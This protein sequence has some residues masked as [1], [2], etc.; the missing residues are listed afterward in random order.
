MAAHPLSVLLRRGGRNVS[1]FEIGG[2][3]HYR[4]EVR[5]LRAFCAKWWPSCRL[6]LP[7]GGCPRPSSRK[8][9]GLRPTPSA[10]CD[11]WRSPAA[12]LPSSNAF[13]GIDIIHFAQ[14]SGPAEILINSGGGL[15]SI[16]VP[17]VVKCSKSKGSA[18]PRLCSGRLRRHQRW[19]TMSAL[20]F[21]DRR[22]PF[23]G[24]R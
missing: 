4:C 5:G 3:G 9:A 11:S 10:G 1:A 7:A 8:P 16:T 12:S 22:R 14:R 2:R 19:G 21:G 15:S 20:A 24:A 18:Q 23:T 13:P 6:F 17:A